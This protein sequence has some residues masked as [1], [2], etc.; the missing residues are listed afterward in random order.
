MRVHKLGVLVL[1]GVIA[2]SSALAGGIRNF[3][4]L[5]A[6]QAGN[7]GVSVASGLLGLVKT[8]PDIAIGSVTIDYTDTTGLLEITG[9]PSTLTLIVP[10]PPSIP[11]EVYTITGGSYL[12]S[13]TLNPTDQLLSAYIT[14]G[15]TTPG[16][17][18]GAP[19]PLLTGSATGP[20]NFGF[21]NNNFEFL[22]DV[23]GGSLQSLFGGKLGVKIGSIGLGYLDYGLMDFVVWSGAFDRDLTN[24]ALG[25]GGNANAD[26]FSVASSAVPVPAALPTGVVLIGGLVLHRVLRRRA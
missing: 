4:N 3:D 13:A 15:G 8:E 20:A 23:T 19:S 14:I 7:G 18:A 12:I 17:P 6:S 26:N 10:N 11:G 9:T 21:D 25:F 16:Y 24:N 5:G 22:F 2:S 1:A